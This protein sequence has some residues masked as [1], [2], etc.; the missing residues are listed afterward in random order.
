MIPE[1]FHQAV[2]KESGQTNHVER[3]KCTLRQRLGCLVR[4]SLS[5]SKSLFWH[6]IRIRLFVLRYN[7]DKGEFY[8]RQATKHGKKSLGTDRINAG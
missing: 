3:L 8:L 6:E 1:E 2:G 7:R 5:F 4:R